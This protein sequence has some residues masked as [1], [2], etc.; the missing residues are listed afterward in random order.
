MI[1]RMI[2]GIVLGDVI[3]VDGSALLLYATK[4]DPH[5][6]APTRF[7]VL[8]SLEGIVMALEEDLLSAGLAAAPI[9]SAA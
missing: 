4:M 2:L 5:A 3:F 9:W 7:I 1:A 8:I 6:L